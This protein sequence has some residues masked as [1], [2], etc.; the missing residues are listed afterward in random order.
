MRTYVTIP[1]ALEG[2]CRAFC[3]GNFWGTVDIIL[4]ISQRKGTWKIPGALILMLSMKMTCQK[5]LFRWRWSR[6]QDT[7]PHSSGQSTP[8]AF[9]L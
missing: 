8:T 4:Y 9:F 1:K 7:R 3:E 6:E 5:L 2:P